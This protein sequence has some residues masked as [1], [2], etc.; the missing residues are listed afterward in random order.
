[1][2]VCLGVLQRRGSLNAHTILHTLI[3]SVSAAVLWKITWKKTG[4]GQVLKFVFL[5]KRHL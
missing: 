5:I 3:L 2:N 1:M 4:T